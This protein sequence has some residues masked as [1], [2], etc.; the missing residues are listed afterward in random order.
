M[1]TVEKNSNGLGNSGGSAS[2]NYSPLCGRCNFGF[3]LAGKNPQEIEVDSEY[4]KPAD[5]LVKDYPWL[6]KRG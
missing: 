3:I 1:L 6:K 2:G 5:Q 4:I